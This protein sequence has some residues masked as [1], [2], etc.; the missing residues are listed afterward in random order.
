M[1][2]N[3]VIATIMICPVCEAPLV[4]SAATYACASGHSF[5]VAREGYVNLLSSRQTRRAINGDSAEMLSARRSF[6]DSGFYEP[7]REFIIGWS[8]QALGRHHGGEAKPVGVLEVGCGEGY[9]IGGAAA[10]WAH[11]E[12]VAFLGTDLS[13]IAAR[14]AAR[15]YP[16]VFFFVADVND[17]ICVRDGSIGL[18]LD[19]FAP[20]NPDEFARVLAPGGSAVIVIPAQ[21]HLAELRSGLGLL[22]IEAEKEARLLERFATQ[23]TVA[24]RSELEFPLEL[25]R[26]AASWL[27]E[28][29]PSHRH[30]HG[31]VVAATT[32]T[33]ASFVI[34]HLRRK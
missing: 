15:R 28:M 29:G 10:A 30:A 6:L 17:R 22:D 8:E 27:V 14:M 12:G 25:P 4:H 23:F 7:L 18:L 3:S 11:S 13:K 33:V 5:D 31:E 21:S 2:D 26:A 20:R 34:L 9:Y 1:H 16:D 24:D 19:V 32:S